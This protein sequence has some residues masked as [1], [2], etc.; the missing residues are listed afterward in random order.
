MALL[1]V[2]NL[3]T[4]YLLRRGTVKAVDDI[5][6]SIEAGRTLGLVG[7]S[8]SGK[9]ATALSLLR[10]IPTPGQIVGGSIVFDGVDLMSLSERQMRDYRGKQISMILQDPLSSLN[11]VFRIGDQI[12]E[13]IIIHEHLHGE[14]L[15][16]RV[17]DLLKSVGIP[18]AE[19]RYYDYPHQFSG[20]MRQRVVGA[21]SLACRPRLLIADEPTT[22]LDVTVQRQYLNLL[23]QLQR[24]ENLAMLFVTHDFGIV[25]KMCDDVA[26]MYAGKIVEMGPVREI[27]NNPT[28]PYTKAL[29]ASVPDVR[30]RAKRLVAIEGQPPSLLNPPDICP[31]LPRCPERFEVCATSP[32][33]SEAEVAPHHCVRCW[34]YV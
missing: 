20:G 5:S 23:K 17:V 19:Q 22:S 14:P 21:I 8:G 13:G 26:V 18:A 10:L 25:A 4:H 1:E 2:K 32:F 33:P 7:E 11:P 28:H 16:T 12:G 24:E 30:T 6:F 9:S 34:H 29:I 3:R 31:F 27:F 15:H